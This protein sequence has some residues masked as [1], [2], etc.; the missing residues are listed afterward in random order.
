MQSKVKVIRCAL[1]LSAITFI[2]GNDLIA[3][4][5]KAAPKKLSDEIVVRFGDSLL[6]VEVVLSYQSLLLKGRAKNSPHATR[7]S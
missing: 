6:K 5:Q 3:K 1:A 2:S 4:P 7:G